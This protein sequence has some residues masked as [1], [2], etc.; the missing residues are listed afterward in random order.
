[1]S[2]GS[3]AGSFCCGYSGGGIVQIQGQQDPCTMIRDCTDLLASAIDAILTLQIPGGATVTETLNQVLL[4]C[5]NF[6]N[7]TFTEMQL[8]L[9]RGAKRGLFRRI[10]RS[11]GQTS[12]MVLSAMVQL[13]GANKQ[14]MRPLCQLYQGRG[15]G[16]LSSGSNV[17]SNF[18]TCCSVLPQNPCSK[19]A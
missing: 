17:D 7:V 2:L 4:T 1:M 18:S 11:D 6:S 19:R 10:A 9:N 13:N 15:S 14:Y 16:T 5:P 3:A 12:Y 8:V